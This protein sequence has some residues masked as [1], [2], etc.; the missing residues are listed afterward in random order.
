MEMLAKASLTSMSTVILTVS[1]LLLVSLCESQQKYRVCVTEKS[2]HKIYTKYCPLLDKPGSK[3]TCVFGHSRLDCLR[4]V[5]D[6]K[7]D[8]GVFEAEDIVVASNYKNPDV[9]IVNE[10]RALNTTYEYEVL[11]IVRKSANITRISQL[12]GKNFC[13]SGYGYEPDWTTVI[14]QYFEAQVVTPV[15]DPDLSTV[16]NLLKSSS[17]YFKAACKAGP[18][19]PDNKLDTKLKQTYSNLCKLCGNPSDCSVNDKYWGSSGPLYCLTDGGGDV[20]WAKFATIEYHFGINGGNPVAP[21]DEYNFLCADNRLTPL[22][23]PEDCAWLAR[24]WATVLSRRKTAEGVQKIMSFLKD[25]EYLSWKWAL[26]ELLEI[27]TQTIVALNQMMVPEDYL[28]KAP[29]FLSA[30]TVTN[31]KPSGNVRICTRTSA[32]MN[33]CDLLQ[34]AASA[35]G[36]KPQL[37][38]LLGQTSESCMKAV[39]T[40]IADVVITQPDDLHAGRKEFALKP[41]LYEYTK[42]INRI[43]RVAAVVPINSPIKRINDLR[44]KKACF[45]V[46]D[47][48]GWNSIFTAL[49]DKGLLPSSCSSV[50]ALGEFFSE[51]CVPGINKTHNFRES[52]QTLCDGDRYSGEVGAFQCLIDGKGEVAFI[53]LN[54]VKENTDNDNTSHVNLQSKNFRPICLEDQAEECYLTWATP[55]QDVTYHF[56]EYTSLQQFDRSYDKLIEELPQ[57][58]SAHRPTFMTSYLTAMAIL[59]LLLMSF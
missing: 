22:D 39:Q 59:L 26:E 45:P 25:V 30:N 54:T 55:G 56:E 21:P 50:E 13:H 3:V 9:L 35:Y 23:K 49:K 57:C 41:L 16:E 14:S 29:G 10:I 4:K 28:R 5:L 47:G 51:S 8:F 11:P 27:H 12:K 46:Y 53:K 43:Q 2:N 32:E 18:W 40:D 19:V 7:A 58:S 44:G 42:N 15:C 24:P 52:L 48:I 31:C 33:K 17:Q 20:A 36:I 1:V 37:E 34:K 38:C 6:G